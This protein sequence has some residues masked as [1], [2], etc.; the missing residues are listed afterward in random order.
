MLQNSRDVD[1]RF[2]S[3]AKL[4]SQFTYDEYKKIKILE[5]RKNNSNN[6]SCFHQVLIIKKE[7]Q[8]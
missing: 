4:T 3:N 6:F 7:I 8:K 1:V 5:E 2:T